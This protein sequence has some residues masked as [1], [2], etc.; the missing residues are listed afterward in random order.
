MG[1][2]KIIDDKSLVSSQDAIVAIKQLLSASDEPFNLA[3]NSLSLSIPI[4]M[5]KQI[6]FLQEFV[7]ILANRQALVIEK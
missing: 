4:P 5:L 2:V 1:K 6:V 7:R 3:V